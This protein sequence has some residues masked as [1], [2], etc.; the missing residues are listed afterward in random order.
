[1]GQFWWPSVKV[2][3]LQ[4]YGLH[5]YIAVVVP[6]GPAREADCFRD[7]AALYNDHLRQAPLYS[8]CQ[9]IAEKFSAM[10]II[11]PPDIVQ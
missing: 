8:H 7:V 9:F 1:M 5:C 4:R 2:A 6:V 11:D 10:C 3:A